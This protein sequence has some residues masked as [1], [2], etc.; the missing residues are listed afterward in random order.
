MAVVKCKYCGKQFDRDKE[1]FVQIPRGSVFRYAHADCYMKAKEN[2]TEVETYEIWDPKLSSFC[3]WCHQAIFPN[4]PDVIPMP[5]LK[6]RYVHKSYLNSKFGEREVDEFYE[7]AYLQTNDEIKEN[8]YASNFNDEFI[9][10][11]FNNSY[12]IYEKI[13]K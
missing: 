7:F 13:E 8:L 1:A 12:A 5:Q 11:M 10:E 4:Q 6:D 9:A 3:F 2:N